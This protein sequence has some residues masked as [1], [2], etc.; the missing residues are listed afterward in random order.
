M[1]GAGWESIGQGA[2]VE[3][4]S[5]QYKCFLGGGGVNNRILD[6]QAEQD[7]PVSKVIKITITSAKVSKLAPG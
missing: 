4:S 7:E 5:R 1:T 2:E 3:K 6:I